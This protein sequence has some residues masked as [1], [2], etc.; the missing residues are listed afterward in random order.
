MGMRKIGKFHV[1]VGFFFVFFPLL[2]ERYKHADFEIVDPWTGLQGRITFISVM[3]RRISSR[4][5]LC[6]QD[7]RHLDIHVYHVVC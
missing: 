2:R 1:L 3:D 7:H 5:L 6:H 4:C